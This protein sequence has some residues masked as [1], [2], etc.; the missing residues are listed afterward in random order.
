MS[1][2]NLLLQAAHV[3]EHSGFDIVHIISDTL[4]HSIRMLPLLFLAYLI[5]EI[6]EH[7]AA[8]KLRK[9]LG[10]NRG[11][12]VGGAILGLF[13]ECGFSV[14]AANLYS[15]RLIGAGTL[16]A[17]FIATSDEALPILL[18][19]PSSARFFLP[20]LII[21]LVCAI[22]AGY[23]LNGIIKLALHKEKEHHHAHEHSHRHGHEH[24]HA[25]GEH[26]HC[27]FCDSNEG[28]FKNSIKRTLTTALFIVVTVFIFHSIVSLVGEDTIEG[29]MESAKYFQ[30]FITA[31]IG[32]VPSCAVSVL[33]TGLF[34]EGVISFGALVAG[35]CAGAGAG[36]AVLLKSGRTFKNSFF[37]IGYI[38]LFGSLAGLI[39]SF[40]A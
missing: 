35:L 13:P 21:K 17:V 39:I 26:H 14:A 25:A 10:N 2:A 24:V 4:L 37:I 16:V 7:K 1:I 29:I 27:E 8:D 15:E 28:I 12:V 23:L 18:S 9:A 30:P 3:H 11:G 38:W 34:T 36:I 6:V 32:L 40:F 33:L 20:M 31:L 5:I 19:M 22:T